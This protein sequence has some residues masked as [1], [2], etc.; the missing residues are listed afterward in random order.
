MIPHVGH[1]P[2]NYRIHLGLIVPPGDCGL[3]VGGEARGWA[4]G[5]VTMFDD[6]FIHEAWNRTTK[7]RVV[8]ITDILNE[9]YR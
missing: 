8:L 2:K 9:K 1:D 5:Q 4:V 7:P 6:T 3:R